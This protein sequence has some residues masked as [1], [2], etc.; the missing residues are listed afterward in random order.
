MNAGG[1]VRFSTPKLNGFDTALVLGWVAEALR[2][3]RCSFFAEQGAVS[4]LSLVLV[5]GS[6]VG[7][8]RPASTAAPLGCG[9][10]E[11]AVREDWCMSNV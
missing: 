11:S 6:E 3:F 1:V 9:L 2:P 5:I 8:G 7:L 4:T 10:E